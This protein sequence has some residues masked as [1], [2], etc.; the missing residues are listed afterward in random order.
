MTIKT[1]LDKLENALPIDGSCP[2]CGQQ[3][4]DPAREAAAVAKLRQEAAEAYQDALTASNG[5][6]AKARD[7]MREC[8]PTLSRYLS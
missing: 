8:A 2:T 1:R 6:E 5:D 7:L 3:R 4:P